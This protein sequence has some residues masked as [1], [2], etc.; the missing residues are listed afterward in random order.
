M[1]TKNK[2]LLILPHNDF[3]DN[4]FRVIH[5]RLNS[6]DI[7]TEIASSHLSEAQGRYKTIVIPDVL[8][9]FVE[10]GDYDGFIFIGEEAA[11]EYFSHPTILRIIDQAHFSHKLVAAIG[12]AVPI[13]AYTGKMSG[14]KVTSS[15]RERRRLEE[16]GTIF[17]G[18]RIEISDHFITA[19]GPEA[20]DEF[21]KSIVEMLNWSPQYSERVYLR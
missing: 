3:D 9:N 14:Q 4:E 19:S 5:E 10:S 7:K 6:S 18:R 2:I 21:A 1:K 13:L 15:E 8:I 11:A 17:T 20:T 16:L 12:A